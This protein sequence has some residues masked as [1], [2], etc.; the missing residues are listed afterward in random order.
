MGFLCYSDEASFAAYLNEQLERA[1]APS[2]GGGACAMAP[3]DPY[4]E[5]D[6]LLRALCNSCCCQSG[7]RWLFSHDVKL[8]EAPATTFPQ[9]LLKLVHFSLQDARILSDGAALAFNLS[10][11]E[12]PREEDA[13]EL[14]LIVLD[15]LSSSK[16]PQLLR[17]LRNGEAASVCVARLALACVQLLDY[18]SDASRFLHK[19]DV[20]RVKWNDLDALAAD[21][22]TKTLIKQLQSS[23]GDV[24]SA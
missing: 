18:C 3:V 9:L 7:Y 13:A 21:E 15:S 14:M 20:D 23:L 8:K 5:L 17:D 24:A 11:R 2:G 19:S 6:Q 10:R 4:V 1:A 22:R 12:P 16:L